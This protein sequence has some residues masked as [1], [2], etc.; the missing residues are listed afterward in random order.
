MVVFE[1]WDFMLIPKKFF[2]GVDVRRY[3]KVAEELLLNGNKPEWKVARRL[4]GHE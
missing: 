1:G 4:E 3:N 2:E